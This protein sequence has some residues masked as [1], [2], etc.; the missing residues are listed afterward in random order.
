MWEC[1]E[2]CKLQLY[3][4]HSKAVVL[5]RCHDDLCPHHG[6]RNRALN[7]LNPD[8]GLH[9]N[10]GAPDQDYPTSPSSQM[11]VFSYSLPRPPRQ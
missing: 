4:S 5:D 2:L 11:S 1:V 7:R 10:Y 3:V 9:G 6:E 8:V